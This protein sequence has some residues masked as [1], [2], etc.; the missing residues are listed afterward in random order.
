M[1]HLPNANILISVQPVEP[2]TSMSVVI[3]R[4]AKFAMDAVGEVI[5][6]QNVQT[7]FP[8]ISDGQVVKDVGVENIQTKYVT[9]FSHCIISSSMLIYT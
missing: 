2:W 7:P 9:L 3:V 8:G 5:T 4:L 6:N 1:R